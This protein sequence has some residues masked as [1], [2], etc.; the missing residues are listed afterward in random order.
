MDSDKNLEICDS[1][2]KWL[3][4]LNLS[5]PHSTP[6]QLSDGVA[7]AEALS[8]ID[9]EMFDGA[10]LSK[11]KR[12]AGANWRVKVSNLKK[13]IEGV[14]IYFTDV[15]NLTTSI[16]EDLRPEPMKIA[17]KYDVVEVGRLLQLILGCAVNCMEKQKYITDIMEL[18]ESLQRNIMTAL[19][20]IE[21]LWQDTNNG[22]PSRNSIVVPNTM[23]VKRVEDDREVLEQKVHDT[24]KKM[25]LLIEEKSTLQSEINRLQGMLDKYENPTL[26]GDDCKSIGKYTIRI[27]N[28][29]FSV[30]KTKNCLYCSVY[31][32]NVN[33][34]VL[35]FTIKV[36]CLYRFL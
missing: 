35:E 25:L 27:K 15:L 5:A 12:D 32:H 18:E 4:V 17:E 11:I 10:W 31:R 33:T 23:E 34:F 8:K 1:L 36:A 14:F 29:G 22:L 19:Q 24:N 6:E 28:G 20:E 9:P 2:I 16:A 30:A 7:L 3:D 26:I 21:Y 13:I